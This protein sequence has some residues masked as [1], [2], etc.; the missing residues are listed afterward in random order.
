MEQLIKVTLG[1]LRTPKALED[2]L[3]D[4]RTTHF[5][6]VATRVPSLPT[7][8]FPLPFLPSILAIADNLTVAAV[9]KRTAGSVK[10]FRCD[11]S[12]I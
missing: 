7:A 12:T 10:V 6:A 5:A 11:V 2:W 1:S 9:A 4:V 3:D 8:H